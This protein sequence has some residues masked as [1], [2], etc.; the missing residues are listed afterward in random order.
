MTIR[1]ALIFV[2][3]LLLGAGVAPP[4]AIAQTAP[5]A[6]PAPDAA[7]LSPEEL[8]KI[9]EAII[10]ESQNPVGNIAIVPFQNNFSY[11]Y[12]PYQRLQY[13]LNIQP[14]VPIMLSPKLN[15]IARLIAPILNNP[16]SAPPEVCASAYGCPGTFG[17][18]DINPQF[19]F[20][21]KT[22]SGALIWGAGPQFLLP[23]GTPSTLSAG[24]Y[25]VGPAIVGLIMPGDIVTGVL[26]TQ[27]WSVAGDAAKPNISTLF[28]Q[29][30]FNY[31]L[32]NA[33]ALFIG[34]SG[35][36]A[37]WVATPQQGKWLVPIGFG[38]SK[39]FKLGDQPMQLSLNYF[40]NV[41]RPAN[42]PYGNIRFTWSLLF[43]VK[44]G[45][46]LP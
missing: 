43:P 31:N 10:K 37:N 16:S 39:T 11:G 21:P 27:I 32:K 42:A 1:R 29:P 41:V 36:T 9:R 13:N 8:A 4:A 40:G 22:K 19:F 24:K 45:M 23:S 44:R 33:W 38:G 3:V 7:N 30:F 25:G 14:V 20:A 26:V 18:G 35:I 15:L 12:G 5:A 2:F 17:I 6:S 28:V 34:S 46:T